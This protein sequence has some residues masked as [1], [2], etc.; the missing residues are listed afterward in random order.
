MVW[1]LSLFFMIYRIKKEQIM[2]K[3]RECLNQEQAASWL[4]VSPTTLRSYSVSGE[5]PCRRIGRRYLYSLDILR[6]WIEGE[7]L[8]VDCADKAKSDTL[9]KQNKG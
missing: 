3:F 2:A 1:N 6:R 8:S 5:I 7:N 9:S 4:G